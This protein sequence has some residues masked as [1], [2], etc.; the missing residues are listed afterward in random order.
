MEGLRDNIHAT[1]LVI[2]DRGVLIVGSSGS[3]KT[4][5]ALTLIGVELGRRRFAALVSDDRVDLSVSSGRLLCA[6]PKAIEGLVEVYGRTPQHLAVEPRA[7]VDLLVRLVPADGAPRYAE[8]A[9]EDI[10]GIRVPCLTL[11]E[12][13]VNGALVA[14]A[15][16]SGL[17]PFT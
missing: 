13:N 5:L 15:S 4:T 14:L 17:P 12:R 3:G 16:V 7:V 6:A 1:A 8:D 9:A 11:A 2:G 10:L